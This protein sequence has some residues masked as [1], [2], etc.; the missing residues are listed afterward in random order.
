MRLLGFAKQLKWRISPQ[1]FEVYAN[2]GRHRNHHY[3]QKHCKPRG[4][5]DHLSYQTFQNVVPGEVCAVPC[6]QIDWTPRGGAGGGE[7]PPSRRP[8]CVQYT[9]RLCC[10][11]RGAMLAVSC[12]AVLCGVRCAFYGYRCSQHVF[13]AVPMFEKGVLSDILAL[14]IKLEISVSY[15]HLTLP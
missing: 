8:R 13:N 10:A 12:F 14:L 7:A 5:R 2:G 11:L 1:V 6:S 3:L 9:L 4:V 15:S